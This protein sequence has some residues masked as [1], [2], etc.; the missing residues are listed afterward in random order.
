[1]NAF[2]EQLMQMR[3]GKQSSDARVHQPRRSDTI[4][5]PHQILC[6]LACFLLLFCN[7]PQTPLAT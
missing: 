7:S 4:V 6:L 2:R 5:V 1:M 3:D